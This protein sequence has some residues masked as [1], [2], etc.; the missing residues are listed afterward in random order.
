MILQL[1]PVTRYFV[2]VIHQ[3]STL[4]SCACVE[5]HRAYHCVVGSS[6]CGQATIQAELAPVIINI[7]PDLI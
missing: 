2:T 1:T 3:H 6:H 5:V 4:K 7:V